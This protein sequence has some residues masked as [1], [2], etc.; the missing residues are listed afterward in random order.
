MA[1]KTNRCLLF[2]SLERRALLTTLAP[3]FAS[4]DFFTTATGVVDSVSALPTPQ[5]ALAHPTAASPID[6]SR[7][8]LTLPI[9]SKGNPTTILPSQLVSGYTSQYFYVGS[10]GAQVFWAPVNGLKTAGSTYPRTELREENPNGTKHNW[11]MADG[12]ATLSATV[13]V[14][15]VP[16]KGGVVIGQIH[17]IGSGGVKNL[18]L[19]ELMY[20]YN[21]TTGTGSMIAET[22]HAPTGQ[23]SIA[24]HVIASGIGLNT[25]VS[26]VI[27]LTPDGTLQVQI[28][29]KTAYTEVVSQSWT[30]QGLYFKAGA[31][32]NDASGP[33]SEGARVAFYALSATHTP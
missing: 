10:D 14:N 22:F 3:S 1:R 13:A 25:Q 20:L 24:K 7:W 9:G 18:P 15:Q 5:A 6:L 11:N 21:S 12:T 27:Q 4:S 16:S 8:Y 23:A 31:Y 2:E 17:D 33:S 30:S 32:P 19:I 28:N 26:Y 29:G